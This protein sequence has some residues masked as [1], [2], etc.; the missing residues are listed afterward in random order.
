MELSHQ[1]KDELRALKAA[2]DAELES[3][4]AAERAAAKEKIMAIAKEHGV[5]LKTLM[6]GGAKAKAPVAVKYRNPANA[7]QAWTGRGRAPQWVA[8][9]RAVGTLE[10]A[11]V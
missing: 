10:A 7:N 9:M 5:D 8:D 2:V 3:R 6:S 1:T 4:D 11:R